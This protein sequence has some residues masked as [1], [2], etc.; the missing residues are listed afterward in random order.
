[1]PTQLSLTGL[2]AGLSAGGRAGKN[3]WRSLAG[4]LRRSVFERLAGYEDAYP[5]EGSPGL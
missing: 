4:L 1:M 5:A 2:A 3:R